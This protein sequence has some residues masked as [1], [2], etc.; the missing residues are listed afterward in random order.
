M[1]GDGGLILGWVMNSHT[2]VGGLTLGWVM[3]WT[4]TGM[5]D[6]GLTLGWVMVWTRTGV[7][8]EL[9][10]GWVDSHWDG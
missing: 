7:G 6:G 8:D 3:V 4:H 9:T 5:G 2:G 10:L 1:V